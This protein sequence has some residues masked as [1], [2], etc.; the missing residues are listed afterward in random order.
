MPGRGAALLKSIKALEA[1]SKDAEVLDDISKSI[2]ESCKIQEVLLD[3]F[4]PEL[5]FCFMFATT[6]LPTL[7]RFYPKDF[8]HFFS[9]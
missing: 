9:E 7:S 8:F 4:K 5:F 1:K 2:V 3:I 6:D